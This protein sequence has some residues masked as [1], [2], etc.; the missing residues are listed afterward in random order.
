[1][2]K[3]NKELIKE[4]GI[5]IHSAKTFALVIEKIVAEKDVTHMDAVILYCEDEGCEPFEVSGLIKRNKALLDKIE[6]N[7]RELNYLPRTA[8]LP[9]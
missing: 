6:N 9:I 2:T 8:V 3:T 1:M 7:A 4:S 5:E